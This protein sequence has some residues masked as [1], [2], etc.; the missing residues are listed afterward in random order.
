MPDEPSRA[1]P[2]P[3]PAD[4]VAPGPYAAEAADLL[5]VGRDVIT[6]DAARTIWRPGAVAISGD[7]IVA[8]GRP[9][10]LRHRFPGVAELGDE[11]A[12]VHPGLINAHQHVTGDRL[13]RS[14]IPDDLPPGASI[15][16]WVV[17][18]HAEHGA[19]DD[20]L[21]ALLSLAEGAANGITTVVEA[22]TVAHPL[23]VARA[24]TAVGV[25]GSIGTWGWDVDD[26]NAPYAAPVNEVLERQ[27]ATVEAVRALANDR[28]HGWVTL[29][30]HDLMSDA[31][32]AG[33]SA[34]ASDLGTHLT[35]HLSP[36]GAD[37][38]SYL[39]RTGARP[40][41][42]LDRL[43]ALGAHV[44]IAHGVH[45]DDAELDALL[46]TRTGVAY[47]PWAYLRL[48]Q[49]VTRAGRHVEL[50]QRGGR[51][52]LGCDA[53][54]ASDSVDL[55]RTCALTAGLAKDM[56]VDPTCFGAHEAFE[57]ATIAGAAAIGQADTLGS[58]EP[59]KLA[60]LVVHD[61]SGLAWTT[62][63][64]DPVLQL[65]WAS[66]GRSVRHVVVGGEVVVRDGVVA[67]VDVAA[68]QREA[69]V[70]GPALAARAGISP[71]ARWPVR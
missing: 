20:E 46:R 25:R 2:A 15:F 70:A 57:L 48:G 24:F 66:D 10:E 58:L 65:V 38:A 61:T 34:L 11:Q 56:A 30:G 16:S 7:R 47:C 1:A 28:V 8:V 69:A 33:A 13:I 35:F 5:V 27:R 63:S 49:G 23:D 64:E 55:L 26:A 18:A 41:V 52:A 14:A 44:L 67:T 22:G 37:A 3:H 62:R 39:A 59:G 45:L 19:R 50:V 4:T 21:S 17:P 12:V 60:D 36:S 53:E 42:H 32:V 6:M 68:L 9:S 29:V 71:A 40:V 43:G 31:L 54:N 51:V